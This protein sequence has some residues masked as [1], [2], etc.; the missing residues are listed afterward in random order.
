MAV[1][2][3]PL[4]FALRFLIAFAVLAGAFEASRGTVFERFVVEDAILVPT[5]ASLNSL[6]PGERVELQGRTIMTPSS[7]LH[8]TR[9]CEG[10]EMF[11]LLAAAILAFP[12][13]LKRRVQ[14]FLVGAGLAYVLAVVRLALLDFVLRYLPGWWGTLHGLVLPLG[15]II[16]LALFFLHWSS[17]SDGSELA[18][19]T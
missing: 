12:A 10:V 17:R 13:S 5:V 3:Q 11:L 4:R 16:I 14:G 9:G 18:H 8:V 6:T 2:S 1:A 19:A 7:R 15:P